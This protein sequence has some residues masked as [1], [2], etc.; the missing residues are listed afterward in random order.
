MGIASL[1]YCSSK[2]KY[3]TKSALVISICCVDAPNLTFTCKLPA[4]MPETFRTCA[5]KRESSYIKLDMIISQLILYR[6]QINELVYILIPEMNLIYMQPIRKVLASTMTAFTA[7]SVA[8]A[9]QF[10]PTPQ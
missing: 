1:Y 4:K 9:K 3:V 8:F 7:C 10:F 5:A 2:Q 6:L